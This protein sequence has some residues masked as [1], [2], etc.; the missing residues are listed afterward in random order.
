[1]LF[2]SSVYGL[3]AKTHPPGVHQGMIFECANR[4]YLHIS[5]M[6]GKT[7]TKSLDEILAVEPL[8]AEELA[9]LLPL[10]QQ[11]LLNERRRV[12]FKTRNRDELI[13]ELLASN[14]VAEAVVAPEQQF[15]HPQLQANNMVVSIDDRDLGPATQIGVPIHLLGTPGGI[16]GPQPAVGADDAAIFGGLGYAA[17]EIGRITGTVR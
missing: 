8:P 6:S 3:M 16:A 2:R 10:Q 15:E 1:V 14:Q 9:D 17:D 5:I 11:V 4:E 7:P 12:A 13:A